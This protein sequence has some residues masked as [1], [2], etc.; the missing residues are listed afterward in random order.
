MMNKLIHRLLLQFFENMESSV[1][2]T[3]GNMKDHKKN[4]RLMR[5]GNFD[6]ASRVSSRHISKVGKKMEEKA[7]QQSLLSQDKRT[8]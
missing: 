8:M 5:E 3:Q 7:K 4:A 6:E 2:M 1:P